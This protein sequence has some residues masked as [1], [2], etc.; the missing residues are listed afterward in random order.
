MNQDND[1]F[2][3][4]L[5]ERELAFIELPED[6]A[7][8]PQTLRE[9]YELLKHELAGHNEDPRLALDLIRVMSRHFGGQQ[10]Y[11]PRGVQLDYYLRDV[12]IW[13]EFDGKNVQALIRKFGVS[14]Q[15]VYKAIAKMRDLE[16]RRR[17]PEL[18]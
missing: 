4:E 2:D 7:K 1:L 18:F 12:Q 3:T 8:W 10:I 17:Q 16:K 14:H 13:E 11:F 9:V 15:T 6:D 5:T